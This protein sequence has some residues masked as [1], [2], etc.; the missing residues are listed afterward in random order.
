[1]LY[2]SIGLTTTSSPDVS[3]PS[4]SIFSSTLAIILPAP[5]TGPAVIAILASP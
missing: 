3:K 2:A 4:D 1:M 5:A